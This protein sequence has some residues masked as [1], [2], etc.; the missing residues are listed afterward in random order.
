MNSFWLREVGPGTA[1]HIVLTGARVDLLADDPEVSA[2]ES[3][4]IFLDG[5]VYER[6]APDAP[7]DV[8][9]RLQWVRRQ[10]LGYRPQPFD[11]LAIVFRQNGD[12]QQARDVL[13]DKRRMR[14]ENLRGWPSR[15]WDYLQDWTVLYGWQPW[16]ALVIGLV[17]LMTVFGL[18]TA[19]QAVGLVLGPSDAIASYHPFIHSLDVFLPIIDL[20]VESR[21]AIDTASG[22]AFAWLVRVSLWALPVVGWVT[23]TLALAALTGIVKRE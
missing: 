5:F 20:G 17:L 13:I 3:V 6:I 4:E 12:E 15:S 10:S 14:R 23:I 16:R 1:G 11:Q 18:V 9:T 19:A 2:R 8:T 21:W 22:G 7:Q